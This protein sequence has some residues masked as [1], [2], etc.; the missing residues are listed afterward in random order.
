[1]K[2][3]H[4]YTSRPNTV[5]AIQWTG[6][7]LTELEEFAGDKIELIVNVGLVLKAGIDGVQGWVKVPVGHWLVSKPN[8]RRDIWPV[9]DNYFK[10]KYVYSENQ[11]LI[12]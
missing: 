1:M 3:V 11:E 12:R 5:D 8:D 4:R 2:S 6:S 7:N 9:E 10:G